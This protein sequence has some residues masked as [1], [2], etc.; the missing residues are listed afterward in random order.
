ML[1]SMG[2]TA[3]LRRMR[4]HNARLRNEGSSNYCTDRKTFAIYHLVCYINLVGGWSNSLLLWLWWMTTLLTS[5]EVPPNAS[6]YRAH[7]PSGDTP[8][9]FVVSS[10][11]NMRLHVPQF[12][13]ASNLPDRCTHLRIVQL[14]MYGLSLPSKKK[15]FLRYWLIALTAPEPYHAGGH[16]SLKQHRANTKYFIYVFKWGCPLTSG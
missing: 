11:Y 3:T 12:V 2:T 7:N 8:S 13:S 9:I 10:Q 16:P 1:R 6:P 15:G 14:A 5:S 4:L